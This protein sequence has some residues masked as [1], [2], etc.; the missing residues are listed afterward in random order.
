MFRVGRALG[1]AGFVVTLALSAYLFEW[2]HVW[3]FNA[4]RVGLLRTL[5]YASA[6][7]AVL[8]LFFSGYRWLPSL[9]LGV[10]LALATV[11]SRAQLDARALAIAGIFLVGAWLSAILV[12]P[13][14]TRLGR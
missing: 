8:A 4:D 1:I 13:P 5:F 12:R 10:G 14:L 6:A 7:G 2:Q 3:P 9:I 11:L